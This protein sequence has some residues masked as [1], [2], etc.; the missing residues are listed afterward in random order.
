MRLGVRNDIAHDR[1]EPQ[2]NLL[3]LPRAVALACRMPSNSRKGTTTFRCTRMTKVRSRTINSWTM[4]RSKRKWWA[5]MT[6]CRMWPGLRRRKRRRKKRRRRRGKEEEAEEEEEEEEDEEEEEEEEEEEVEEKEA[7]EDVEERKEVRPA[8][9]KRA[10]EEEAV[11]DESD[12]DDTREPPRENKADWI[13]WRMR[14][15]FRGHSKDT[16]YEMA[17]REHEAAEIGARGRKRQRRMPADAL[18]AC[19]G[20]LWSAKQASLN[21]NARK[22]SGGGQRRKRNR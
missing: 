5:M 17:K 1:K 7:Q 9:S 4:R 3:E 6:S 11:E 13:Q 21:T 8:R 2:S 20:T 18:A 12:E 16:P 15:P 19:A 14:Q 22:K 10:R